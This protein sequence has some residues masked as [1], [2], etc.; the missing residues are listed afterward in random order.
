MPR[1]VAYLND[2]LM[3]QVKDMAQ[4]N[5]STISKTVVELIK[6]GYKVKQLQDD[7]NNDK[8]AEK[9]EKLI[10]KHTEYLL[11][12]LATTTDVLR[13][14]HNDQ[15]K[16]KDNNIDEISEIIADKMRE[17]INGYIGINQ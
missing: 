8:E 2:N 10:A 7:K 14:V 6:T 11:R 13:C 9:M 3:Q 4:K 17:Y 15:S 5:K 1:L 12:I 16:Y